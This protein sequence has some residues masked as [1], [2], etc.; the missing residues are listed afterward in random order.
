LLLAG[1]AIEGAAKEN[2]MAADLDDIESK[3]SQLD[4]T[5]IGIDTGISQ[6]NELL[7]E[8]VKLMKEL[9]QEAK[10]K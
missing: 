1:C 4:L 10:K 3:L 2:Y 8:I 9:I 7:T 5:L 6:S